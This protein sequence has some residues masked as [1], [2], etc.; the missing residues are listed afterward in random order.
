MLVDV[1]MGV[2]QYMQNKSIIC[3][4]NHINVSSTFYVTGFLLKDIFF[5]NM[6]VTLDLPW[7]FYYVFLIYF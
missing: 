4:H 2:N 6:T 1:P 5:C 7:K 3:K